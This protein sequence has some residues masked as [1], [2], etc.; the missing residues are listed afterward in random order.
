MLRGDV[1]VRA[2]VTD[3]AC[4][5]PTTLLVVAAVTALEL[6]GEVA[7]SNLGLGSF[8]SE[9]SAH[10]CIETRDDVHVVPAPAALLGSPRL[11]P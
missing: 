3:E 11:E 9:S 1:D 6:L 10:A 2:A 5:R 4:A 7:L 8:L